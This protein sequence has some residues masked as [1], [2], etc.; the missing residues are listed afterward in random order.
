[1]KFEVRMPTLACLM[2]VLCGCGKFRSALPVFTDGASTPQQSAQILQPSAFPDEQK[3]FEQL[4]QGPASFQTFCP[5]GDK[6]KVSLTFCVTNPPT[7]TGLKDLQT[8]LGL[9]FTNPQGGNGTGGNPA[10]TLTGHSSSLVMRNV[11]SIN[12]RALIFTPNVTVPNPTSPY[13]AMGFTRGEEFVE[14][15][16]FDP[17]QGQ[18]NAYL[19]V[20]KKACNLTNTCTWFDLETPEVEKNWVSY[21]VYEDSGAGDPTGNT[22]LD[23]Q[24]CHQQGGT[25]ANPILRMQEITSPFTHFFSSKTE[26]G[27]ALLS[28]FHGAHGTNE[29]YAGI[30][31]AMLDQSDPSLLAALV[32]NAGFGTQPNAFPSA[33]I[34]AEVKASSPLQPSDNIVAGLS[35][36]WQM[37]Y[38]GFVAG[39][40]I[41]PPYHDVK[42]TD[43]ARLA[44][45]TKAY[46]DAVAGVIA[47]EKMP[48]IRGAFTTDPKALA[49][50]GIHIQQGLTDPMKILTNACI[51][52]HNSNLDQTISRSNFNVQT[53][54]NM[55]RAEKDIAVLRINLPVGALG[56]MPPT[57]FREL[58]PT[59]RA[60]LTAFLQQ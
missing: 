51:Q 2:A 48:D 23:C 7:L 32:T 46:Q 42:I 53:F 28:D 10:F 22:M 27:S 58:L 1:M 57:R 43:P 18:L 36:T 19:V 4:P 44:A 12:P 14:I 17:S 15:M 29:D 38:N 3:L 6:D 59:E 20:F 52:C 24:Q 13:T 40:F 60:L 5:Q 33:T 50:M 8:V 35:A 31:A 16:S 9:N 21:S 34:E 30:P 41:A 37:L 26:G 54:A 11:T 25:S 39:L 49:D 47:P 56:T 45:M 55:S